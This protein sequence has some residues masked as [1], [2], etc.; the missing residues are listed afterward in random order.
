MTMESKGLMGGTRVVT[1]L[2]VEFDNGETKRF[3]LS[4]VEAKAFKENTQG[5]MQLLNKRTNET[6]LHVYLLDENVAV[7]N[8]SKITSIESRTFHVVRK[9]Q[10]KRKRE[11]W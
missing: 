11:T 10:K 8:L 9:V 5:L 3:L 4:D 7:I 2:V 1:G 6:Y